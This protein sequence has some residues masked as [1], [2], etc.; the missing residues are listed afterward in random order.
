MNISFDVDAVT[1]IVRQQGEEL[2]RVQKELEDFKNTAILTLSATKSHVEHLVKSSSQ[3]QLRL[4]TMK[5][6]IDTLQT[7]HDSTLKELRATR[8][9]LDT[10][11]SPLLAG[12]VSIPEA[13][14]QSE[15]LYSDTN[16][17]E[18]AVEESLD[19][20]VSDTSL[21]D[22]TTTSICGG[23]SIHESFATGKLSSDVLGQDCHETDRQF[24]D[25]EVPTAAGS[26]LPGDVLQESD[27]YDKVVASAET[28]SSKNESLPILP[29]TTAVTKPNSILPSVST[30]PALEAANSVS[31]WRISIISLE[32]I[33][34]KL[35]VPSTGKAVKDLCQKAIGTEA[36][37][38]Y[39]ILKCPEA[40]FTLSDTDIRDQTLVTVSKNA[41][42]PCK[43]LIRFDRHWRGHLL[44]QNSIAGHLYYLGEFE[45]GTGHKVTPNEYKDSFPEETKAYVLSGGKSLRHNDIQ[46]QEHLLQSMEGDGLHVTKTELRFFGYSKT[47]EHWLKAEML[48]ILN[49]SGIHHWE[50][51]DV[52]KSVRGISQLLVEI[53]AEHERVEGINLLLL[54]VIDSIVQTSSSYIS[55]EKK[56]DEL[57]G[58]VEKLRF[59][60]GHTHASLESV[61]MS[62]RSLTTQLAEAKERIRLQSA[63]LDNLNAQRD[64]LYIVESDFAIMASQH[65]RLE[66]AHRQMETEMNRLLKGS[67]G[68]GAAIRSNSG[69]SRSPTVFD[70][71][72]AYLWE[73]ETET[74]ALLRLKI[75]IP[76]PFTTEHA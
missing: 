3:W 67:E 72:A 11:L 24:L 48:R 23:H 69:S 47:I 71:G 16:A 76:V 28:E 64:H 38:N 14:T 21:S 32:P 59:I 10:A 2:L 34:S 26:P 65:K 7:E 54:K 25:V 57:S 61:Q 9:S 4:T 8:T 58:K 1:N 12:T 31:S 37:V 40:L 42:T 41:A 45:S 22:L 62:N 55:L 35:P 63:H 15:S 18:E 13:V 70:Q 53:P 39:C 44:L 52:L 29:E 49:E 50:L 5:S 27:V 33:L 60:I 36:E 19:G 46:T 51:Q 17:A 74:M 66:L 68:Y 73:I 20:F 43:N 30:S 75:Q 56:A 6:I